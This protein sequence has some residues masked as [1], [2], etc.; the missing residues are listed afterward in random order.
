MA[1]QALRS[2]SMAVR[3]ARPVPKANSS[4]SWQ[5][6][7]DQRTLDLRVANMLIASGTV[8]MAVGGYRCVRLRSSAA[9]P[10]AVWRF[11]C[12]N[13]RKRF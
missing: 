9:D 5:S 2:I 4:S 6:N 12:G 11:A 3:R 10:L 8:M 7:T 13:S 1:L